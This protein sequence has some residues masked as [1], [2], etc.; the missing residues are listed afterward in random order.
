MPSCSKAKNP[1]GV[2]IIFTEEDHKY[3]SIIDGQEVF[4][5]SGT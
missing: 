2:E 3:K 4:Y 1:R 5:T